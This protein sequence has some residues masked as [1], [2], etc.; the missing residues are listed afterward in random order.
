MRP[1][2]S[3]RAKPRETDSGSQP[4]SV[5]LERVVGEA[6]DRGQALFGERLTEHRAVLDEPALVL[7]QAVEPGR[8]ECVQCF[9]HFQ[10]LNRACRPVDV[11]LLHQQAAVEQHADSLDRIQR[12]TLGAIE[13][14]VAQVIG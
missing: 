14:P 12:D 2:F 6:G 7:S 13:D 9:R 11:S 3:P 5:W 8:N 1:F 4:G 10:R